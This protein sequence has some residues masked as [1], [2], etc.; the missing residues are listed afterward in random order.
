MVRLT[1]PLS[2]TTPDTPCAIFSACGGQQGGGGRADSRRVWAWGPVGVAVRGSRV[3]VGTGTA[4]QLASPPHGSRRARGRLRSKLLREGRQ[5]LPRPRLAHRAALVQGAARAARRA[6]LGVRVV[7]GV[8]ALG[9]GLQ[10]A[11]AAVLLRRGR[12]RVAGRAGCSVEGSSEG[13][14]HTLSPQ[15]GRCAS[16]CQ[17]YPR[18]LISSNCSGRPAGG[19]FPPPPTSPPPKVPTAPAGPAP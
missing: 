3:C 6:H 5:L 9:H 16:P 15:R 19:P 10:G 12:P 17:D 4:G 8:A 14:E 2:F 18:P 1:L 7:A 11:H 13:L